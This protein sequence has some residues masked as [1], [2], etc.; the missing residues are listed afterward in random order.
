MI[1]K[2][3]FRFVDDEVQIPKSAKYILRRMQDGDWQL[4]RCISNGAY[5]TI[6][7]FEG[8]IIFEWQESEEYDKMLEKA[9]KIVEN[10]ETIWA[11]KPCIVTSSEIQEIEAELKSFF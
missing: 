6:A 5:E 9:R 1:K 11:E 7:S 3:G 2:K 8:Q 4:E 10:N